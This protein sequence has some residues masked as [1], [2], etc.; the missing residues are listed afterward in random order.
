MGL[1]EDLIDII[2]PSTCPGCGKVMDSG[3]LWCE[4]CLKTIWDPGSSTHP[5]RAT[6]KAV[7]PFAV[8]KAPFGTASS[9][10]NITTGK[11]KAGISSAVGPFSLLAAPGLF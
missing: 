1:F 3:G 5:T 2:Y 6:S 7:T 8:T 10:L 11:K 9:A 4:D